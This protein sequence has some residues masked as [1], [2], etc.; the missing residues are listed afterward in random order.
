MDSSKAKLVDSFCGKCPVKKCANDG[1]VDMEKCAC[2][3]CADNWGGLRCETCM[4]K[5]SDCQHGA[6][7]DKARV[8]VQSLVHSMG[9]C[10][11][12]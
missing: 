8:P 12:M 2:V 7:L 11:L 1:T 4:L 10:A 3:D 5:D 6:V 9:R